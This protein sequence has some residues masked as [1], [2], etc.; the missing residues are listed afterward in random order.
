MPNVYLRLCSALKHHT[1][2]LASFEELDRID[3]FGFRGEALS[4]LC[5]LARLTVSTVT[6]SQAP[7]GQRL[8]YDSH[9]RLVKQSPIAR[10]VGFFIK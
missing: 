5:A 6:E 4:S 10:E 8:E 1:S 9:G 3:S 7:T 2:K